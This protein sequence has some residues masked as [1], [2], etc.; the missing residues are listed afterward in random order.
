MDCGQH[1]RVVR[2]DDEPW[3]GEA[4]II[5]ALDLPLNIEHNAHNPHRDFVRESRRRCKEHARR[6][7]DD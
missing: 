6:L 3:V 5:G 4:A 2:E 1:A 7:F